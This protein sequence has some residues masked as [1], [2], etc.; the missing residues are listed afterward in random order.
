M[1]SCRLKM[2]CSVEDVLEHIFRSSDIELDLSL[3]DDEGKNT[4]L[5]FFAIY[6]SQSGFIQ[7][8]QVM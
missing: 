8:L 7:H 1:A 2:R 6:N 5:C 4:L 3:E